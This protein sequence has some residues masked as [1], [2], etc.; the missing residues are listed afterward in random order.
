MRKISVHKFDQRKISMEG[1]RRGQA[2]NSV[3]EGDEKKAGVSVDH[4][5]VHE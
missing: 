2:D 5:E 1:H 4:L 3:N